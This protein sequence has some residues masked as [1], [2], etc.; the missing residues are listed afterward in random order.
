MPSSE[1]EA[2]RA[3]VK[4][5]VAPV[6]AAEVPVE[7]QRVMWE[8]LSAISDRPVLV[9]L[10][11]L[12]K[13]SPACGALLN[14][15]A[16]RPTL[17]K[18][19]ARLAA[20]PRPNQ[21]IEYIK[22]ENI[23]AEWISTG[24]SEPD[25]VLFYLHGGGYFLGSART[26]RNFVT[27]LAKATRRQAVALDYRLAP[28][29]P[30]PAALEDALAA[31]RW[32][33]NTKHIRPEQI[34]MAGDSAGGGL[35]LATLIALRDAGEALP[36]AAVLMS[37]WTDHNF[38]GAS[39]VSRAKADP[40]L[41]PKSLRVHSQYYRGQADPATPLISPLYADLR[42]LPPLLI[43]V[44]S[45]EILL[46]DATRLAERAKEAGVS[47]ELQVGEEMWHVWQVFVAQLPEAQQAVAQIRD[48]ITQ[49]TAVLLGLG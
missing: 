15:L 7:K 12:V 16:A 41:T 21:H 11:K 10:G 9:L 46:D 4:S 2:L 19:Q 8:S 27:A 40:I 38:T 35:V 3:L 43:Q 20:R 24:E 25:R 49:N 39:L 23:K 28:E 5:Q 13:R 45:D 1:S 14:F 47:V 44:G 22:T 6:F 42:G 33:V 36:A 34:V 37:P 18:L 31:Y 32:L 30:F 29:H 48:F 17:A 26:Y